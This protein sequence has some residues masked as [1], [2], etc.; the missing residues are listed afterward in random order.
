[1][2]YVYFFIK[3]VVKWSENSVRLEF[4][5]GIAFQM[6]KFCEILSHSVRYGMYVNEMT[7]N[8]PIKLMT[9][10]TTGLRM[11]IC[12]CAG[13]SESAHF[14]HVQRQFFA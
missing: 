7:H 1:M 3:S 4:F 12:A 6:A 2:I 5:T 13:L 11:I 10:Q 8:E 14:A 9:L